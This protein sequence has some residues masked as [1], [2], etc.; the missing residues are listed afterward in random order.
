MRIISLLSAATLLCASTTALGK[1][2]VNC[3]VSGDINQ[4]KL[5]QPY[6]S[7]QN[8]Y[9][10]LLEVQAD[11]ECEVINVLYSETLL[12]GGIV[13]KDGQRLEGNKG[14]NGALPVITNTTAALNGFGIILA[15][16]NSIK[17]IHVKDTLTSGILGSYLVQPVGGDL[18]IQ[19]TL[20]TGAN[21]SAGFS[22][23]AQAWASVGIVSEADMNLVI[24]NSE[25]G[26]ADA[27]SVGI[28]QL[29]GHAEVQISHT[30]VRDQ[31]H[32]PGGSNVSSG[33]TVIAANNSSVDVLI[34]NTSVSNIGHDTLSNSDGLLLLNQGSG[35]MTVLVD[36]YRYSNPDDGGKIGT[37]T[38]IEMG[39]FDSTGG[40]SFSGI[41]TNSIIEDAWHAGIQVLDQFSGGSNTLTVEIRDNKIKNCA[42]GI[43]GFMDATPNSSMFLN[44]TDNV[45]DSP[46]DR[47]EGR[48][49]GGGIYIGLSRAVLDVAEVFMENNLIVNSETT[50]LEFSLFNATA[51]SILLD[52]GLG[53]LG[54]A[55]QNRIINSGVFDISAD[56]VSVSAAGNWWGSDTGPAFLNELNGGTINVTPFLTADPNP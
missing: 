16:D 3:Y 4:S 24:E 2:P 40:G 56:G 54:S 39:F 6:G 44:I 14:K 37:S 27:P 53:G 12:D 25:I 30:K 18:K 31:G 28:I 36:G 26:E 9:G 22:P 1:S 52:S 38:G 13:L 21:Q 20:V 45:I 46:T 55:G 33:I 11:P 23:F 42:Q 43:Q 47:G 49:L 29:V 48:E 34:N 41:V 19:N 50:G 7:K 51:N 17:H 15:I 8:P 32:L 35:A 10:S 5:N